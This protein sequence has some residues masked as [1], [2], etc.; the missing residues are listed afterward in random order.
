MEIIYWFKNSK[1]NII[2]KKNTNLLRN[3]YIDDI[4]KLNEGFD[5]LYPSIGEN[6]DF[7]NQ[8]IK[9]INL[10]RNRF[11]SLYTGF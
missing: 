3:F 10:N 11:R 1:K 5:V 9:H 2:S 8:E 6:M 7:L 4:K